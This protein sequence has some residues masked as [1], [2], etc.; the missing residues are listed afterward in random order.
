MRF[1]LPTLSAAERLIAEN[2]EIGVESNVFVSAADVIEI[3]TIKTDSLGAITWIAKPGASLGAGM[4]VHVSLAKPISAAAA[5]VITLD[6]TVVTTG[7]GTVA[8]TFVVPAWVGNQNQIYPEGYAL[9]MIPQGVGNSARLVTAVTGVT[10]M[11]NVPANSELTVWA[12]PASSNFA[13]LGW[14][15]SVDGA[16]SAYT[17][18]SIANKYNPTAASKKGVGEIKELNMDFVAV[19]TMDGV[20]RYDGMRVA[21]LVKIIKDDAVHSENIVYTGHNLN[22]STKRGEGNDAVIESSKGPFQR[23]L[24]FVAP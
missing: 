23:A 12:S 5:P 20:S 15:K 19:S 3:G 16:Y 18:V 2:P 13:E 21:V 4:D 9:D 22:A 24:K 7:A 11:T 1:S 17:T 6:A 8:G 14:K 10:S